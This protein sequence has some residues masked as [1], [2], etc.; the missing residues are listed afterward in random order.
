[1]T[2]FGDGRE[3]VQ[4]RDFRDG[5]SNTIVVVESRQ[6]VP[7]T[8]PSDID[9]GSGGDVP[10]FGGFDPAGSLVLLGDTAVTFLP[11]TVSQKDLRA[12][13]TRAGG[14]RISLP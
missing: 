10:S 4:L 7:W 14:E 3:E 12:F 11:K 9:V 6:G 13:V 8:K 5:I 2:A 1:G